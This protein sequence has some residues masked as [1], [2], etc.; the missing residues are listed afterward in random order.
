MANPVEL[1]DYIRQEDL[2]G[3][4]ALIRDLCD[5]E[6]AKL[7]AVKLNGVSVYIPDSALQPARLRFARERLAKGWNIKRIAAYLSVSERWLRCRLGFAAE[8][9][10]Q[11]L[12]EG[13]SDDIDAAP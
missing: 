10:D 7:L 13:L 1:K 8:V 9:P 12:F 6:T 3:D 2:I 11:M 5:L 4:L